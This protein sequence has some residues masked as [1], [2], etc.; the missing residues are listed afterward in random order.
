M[1]VFG[2]WV[3]HYY[4]F[5]LIVGLQRGSV[6]MDLLMAVFVLYLCSVSV[7]TQI[8]LYVPFQC[9]H[10]RREKFYVAFV[11]HYTAYMYTHIQD[12]HT[13][14]TDHFNWNST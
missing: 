2:L 5:E 10:Y 11:A 8:S 12:E 3:L 7:L 6:K 13:L 14:I 4:C 9:E 1:I